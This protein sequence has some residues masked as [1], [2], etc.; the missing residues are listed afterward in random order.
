MYD[1]KPEAK[2]GLTTYCKDCRRTVCKT[3]RYVIV[4]SK[5]LECHT[6]RTGSSSHLGKQRKLQAE[7]EVM[8]TEIGVDAYI[9][10]A[11]RAVAQSRTC[12]IQAMLG[13]ILGCSWSCR[14]L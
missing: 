8:L 9:G 4:S 14:N 5:G 13:T 3:C 1:A 10:K 12:T 6:C 7:L 11:R 2:D